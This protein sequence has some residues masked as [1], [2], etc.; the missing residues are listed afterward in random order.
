MAVT[1]TR[2]EAPSVAGVPGLG[3]AAELA[4]RLTLWEERRFEDLLRRDEEHLLADATRQL[5]QRPPLWLIE[6]ARRPQLALIARPPPGLSYLCSFL[7][8]ATT[9]RR[10]KELLHTFSLGVQTVH[11]CHTRIFFLV[12][13][14]LKM[15]ECV[16]CCLSYQ[17]F[18]LIHVSR[19]FA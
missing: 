6:L 2:V 9:S 18:H 12:C 5:G 14:W 19:H 16:V 8:R 11:T 7:R 1:A 17:S 10:A 4:K 3:A 13:T 15:F